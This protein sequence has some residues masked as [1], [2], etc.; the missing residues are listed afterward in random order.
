MAEVEKTG[1]SYIK[2]EEKSVSKVPSVAGTYVLADKARE[3][4]YIGLA[5]NLNKALMKTLEG[6]NAC[7]QKAKFFQISI[8]PDP[9][10]GVALIF[11]E[12]KEEHGGFIPRCNKYDLSLGR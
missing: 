11:E 1:E 7:L 12:Y 3:I 6:Y 5:D 9:K 4:V 2:L 10:K 8:N